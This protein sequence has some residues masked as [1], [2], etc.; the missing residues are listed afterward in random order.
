MT[1]VGW[2]DQMYQLTTLGKVALAH[3]GKELR[4]VSSHR[5]KMAL[6]TYLALEGQTARDTL[7]ALFWG[8]R[9]QERA[10][11]SL[12][13]TLYELRRELGEGFLDT[14]GD[15]LALAENLF[16]VDV[17]EFRAA[18][19]DGRWAD[20]LSVYRGSFLPGFY[21]DA[22]GF[23]SW[24]EAQ[25]AELER[26][27][28]RAHQ[29][30]LREAGRSGDMKAA[31]AVARRWVTN[32][33]LHDEAQ[34]HLIMLLGAMGERSE[35]IQQYE[36][37]ASRLKREYGLEP[38]DEIRG[39]V[40]QIRVGALAAPGVA[41]PDEA[42]PDSVA[43]RDEPVDTLAVAAEEVAPPAQKLRE[44]RIVRVLLV[45]AGYAYAAL[46]ATGLFTEQFALSQTVFVSVLAVLLVGGLVIAVA[47]G[48]PSPERTPEGMVG[49]LVDAASAFRPLRWLRARSA[50]VK[51]EY[52]LVMMVALA[53]TLLALRH[54]RP[55]DREI[56]DFTVL[57]VPFSVGFGSTESDAE[58]LHEYIQRRLEQFEGARLKVLDAQ[59]LVP[60]STLDRRSAIQLARKRGARYVLMCELWS[61]ENE[62]TVVPDL[63]DARSGRRIGGLHQTGSEAEL[64]MLVDRAA[65][66]VYGRLAD[67]L[68]LPMVDPSAMERVSPE[69][70]W[71]V[72]SG[73][74]HFRRA[75]YEKAA[76]EF[77]RAIQADTG[78]A[79][80]YFHLSLAEYWMPTDVQGVW[81]DSAKQS[82][83]E[84]VRRGERLGHRAGAIARAQ[85]LYMQGDVEAAVKGYEQAQ[86]RY[87]D[88]LEALLGLA[89]S[90]YHLGPYAGRSPADAEGA[91]EKL[92]EADSNYTLAYYHL[93]DLAY[94]RDDS[95]SMRRYLERFLEL[96]ASDPDNPQ[97][98]WM[99]SLWRL[100]YGSPAE[101]AGVLRKLPP[102]FEGLIKYLF[103]GGRRLTLA[104]SVAW[105]VTVSDRSPVKRQYGHQFRFAALTALGHWE[106]A[107][108]ERRAAVREGADPDYDSWVVMSYL[109]GYPMAEL[110][111]PMIA[112]ALER[113]SDPL[114]PAE[115]LA[116]S[117]IEQ[118]RFR[119]LVQ[120]AALNGDSTLVRELHGRLRERAGDP[121]DSVLPSQQAALD[122][123]LAMLAGDTTA[124][125][126]ALRRSLARFDEPWSAFAPGTVMA[127]QRLQLAE[128]LIMRG[129]Y[130]G[131]LWW[132]DSFEWSFALVDVFCLY[133]ARTLKTFIGEART[134]LGR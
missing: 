9:E 90:Y 101:R 21:L 131:A 12:S 62:M 11:H 2:K 112:D 77:R 66:E 71:A 3:D 96:S 28:R 16:R 79:L 48:W 54:F 122:A 49:W 82:L 22:P 43:T 102:D 123:R 75:E 100:E 119:G 4:R 128:L 55:F 27:Q 45:Y 85:L 117:H 80:A 56:D 133:Q 88:D 18:A 57:A 68:G 44:R 7:L 69:A 34:R 23:E 81:L 107:I 91:F 105:Q 104:D 130:E 129:D 67:R 30:L 17:E 39:L 29:E 95:A 26:L 115:A 33:P 99:E 36:R 87:P 116:F 60:D 76:G 51:A 124:A 70:Q 19:N 84:A 58:R 93:I 38:L 24:V 97:R 127:L 126:I 106:E 103:K 89:E 5:Q 65:L 47:L 78:F 61:S 31:L 98:A 8:E 59:K 114:W 15:R 86:L 94:Q 46:E 40:D 125:I 118:Q 132:L 111:E 35:A 41:V 121:F 83:Q 13:Q 52:V 37:Y 109:A 25:R 110:A 74:H 63:L 73:V 10:R 14:T 113:L 32:D 120:Y 1:E 92:V 53:A 108:E 64:R 134:E 72:I 6:L 50:R 20:A 42:T